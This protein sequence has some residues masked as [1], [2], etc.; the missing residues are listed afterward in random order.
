[1]TTSASTPRFGP[2]RLIRRLRPCG[3]GERY[4]AVH[5]EHQSSHTV[6]RLGPFHGLAERR[7][8]VEAM[9]RLAS[10]NAAHVQ[11][12][13]KY[14][15]DDT[16]HG[17][18]VADYTGNQRGLVQL[19]DLLAAKGGRFGVAEAERCIRQLLQ[20]F[21]A[22]QEAGINH[23]PLNEAD[24]LVDPRGSQRVQLFGVRRRLEGLMDGAEELGRDEVRSVAALGYRVMT[25]LEADEPLIGAS[26]LVKRLDRAWDGWF[27]AM[28]DPTLC[29]DRAA[30]AAAMLPGGELQP[31]T[32]EGPP[33]RVRTVVKRLRN[34]R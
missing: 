31:P 17:W 12:F 26:R 32:T 5:D 20:A 8:W 3:I 33:A 4:L 23:G 18:A 13:E 14:C 6:Y 27:D 28:L 19:S 9:D 24:V 30:D 7:R 34:A 10:T 11:S 15:L 2:F 1:M 21:S 29:P 16:G 22:G 25:G